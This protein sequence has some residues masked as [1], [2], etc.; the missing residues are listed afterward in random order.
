MATVYGHLEGLRPRQIRELEGF[1]GQKI[2]QDCIVTE[3]LAERLCQVSRE[4][5]RQIG[6]VIDR[7]G[8]V[9]RVIAGDAR[10]ILIPDLSDFRT[11]PGRLRGVRVVHTHLYD[12]SLTED[13]LTD[14]ALLRLDLI[15]ALCATPK[16]G[17]GAVHLAHVL[18]G[19]DSDHPCQILPPGRADLLENDCLHFILELEE[20][21]GRYGSLR[22]APE[23]VER[24]I[25]VGVAAGSK[26]EIGV[27]M[28]ELEEL[29]ETNGVYVIRSVVQTRK[30]V[31]PKTLVGQGKLK[32]LYLMALQEAAT[33]VIFD[34][35]LSPAQVRNI[36]DF[37][38][39]K[40][41]DR[42][43]L[44]LDIF[45]GRARSREGKLQVELAQLKYLQPRLTEK[46]TAM[47]RLTGGIGG[48]GPGE[49]KLEINRRRVREQIQRLEKDV[50]EVRKRRDQQKA[51]RNRQNLP[52]FSIVGY[53][54]AGK[55]TLL[56][57]LTQSQVHAKDQLFATLDP[58]SRRLR[59]PRDVEVIITDT[60]GFIRDLP[61]ELMAA[62]QA[63][64]E[65]LESADFLL[66][67]I[68]I[69][70]PSWEKQLASVEK[71][72]ETLDLLKIPQIRV[73]NK[74]DL[75]DPEFAATIAARFD[76]IAVSAKS[77][78]S[79]IPL[80]RQMEESLYRHEGT[81]SLFP[82]EAR[83]DETH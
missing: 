15:C 71:I 73:F 35:E 12:E 31:D 42:T 59:F 77:R 80:L 19:G 49:T 67:V 22:D 51:L 32:D 29:A 76:G 50:K 81:R 70:S 25:L 64:L 78:K 33:L 68:D 17:V 45:A 41:L 5:N 10:E 39:I 55:S 28:K 2:P 34:Q 79:L 40:V 57:T 72:L 48:R 18:P 46:N 52:V 36:S 1:Y 43:Q 14:L 30:K 44:I 54:N 61:K 21:I 24:A 69:S 23:G 38:E 83:S 9:V 65:E 63:T 4:M 7:S 62:F 11:A 74:A 60:V 37:M 27:H 56:N 6:L 8:K 13:D 66:H 47:S 53:T 16:G 82:E 26:D 58:T 3:K 20:E 75:V